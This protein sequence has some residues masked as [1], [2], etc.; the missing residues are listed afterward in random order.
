MMKRIVA[1]L[2]LLLS[3]GYYTMAQAG[4][5][6]ATTAGTGHVLTVAIPKSLNIK[7]NIFLVNKSP[8]LILQAMVALPQPD[9]NFEPVGTTTLLAA[10]ERALIAS[11]ANNGLK[12]LRGTTI[13]VKVKGAKVIA[14]QKR[15]GVVTPM[16]DV[17][18]ATTE[19]SPDL[20]N[21]I[22][23]KDVTYDYDV[24]IYEA[25]HDLYIEVYYKGKT[26]S[27]MDF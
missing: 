8:Y 3:I 19:I 26:G 9:G 23:P 20:V 24:R 18:A 27:V 21:N 13:A 5:D 25:H 12:R 15:T 2:F 14:G 1:L 17:G 11:Y 4:A 22:D 6:S 7:D 10:D 16:G